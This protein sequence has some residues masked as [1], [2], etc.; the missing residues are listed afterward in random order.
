MWASEASLVSVEY[1]SLLSVQA[2]FR[3]IRCISSLWRS[4]I[5]F[6]LKYSGTSVLLN[7]YITGTCILLT[8]KLPSRGSRAMGLLFSVH[9]I[10][11]TYTP[12]RCAKIE[13]KKVPRVHV[14]YSDDSAVILGLGHSWACTDHTTSTTCVNLR[15]TGL[16]TQRN[17]QYYWYIAGFEKFRLG[18]SPQNT[19]FGIYSEVCLKQGTI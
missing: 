13:V 11:W 8:S 2:Q 1:L 5:Y 14:A 10:R 15:D 17:T 7:L 6:W 16:Y 12:Y 3:V 19:I 9:V 18:M 4:C